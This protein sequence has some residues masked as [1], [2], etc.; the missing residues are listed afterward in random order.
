MCTMAVASVVVALVLSGRVAAAR[1]Q[2]TSAGEDEAA[3][4]A[5]GEAHADDLWR[6]GHV[7]LRGVVPDP[8]AAAEAVLA[9]GRRVLERCARCPHSNDVFDEA[10]RGC[11]RHRSTTG[12]KSFNK[13]RNL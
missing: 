12:P 5:L 1:G 6:D 7:V 10:C 8:A 11:H 4:R 2:V 3:G 13:A 9:A